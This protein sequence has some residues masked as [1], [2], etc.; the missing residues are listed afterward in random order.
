M[1]K[2]PNTTGGSKG[3]SSF[4]THH[5]ANTRFTVTRMQHNKKEMSLG[6]GTMVVS[7]ELVP[8]DGVLP[9]LG[10]VSRIEYVLQLP[11]S[12]KDQFQEVRI[13]VFFFSVPQHLFATET[14]YSTENEN[15]IF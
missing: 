10:F 8:N 12:K 11:F 3:D 5:P 9:S 1:S 4:I 7:V 2:V 6:L 13:T 15:Q 14:V